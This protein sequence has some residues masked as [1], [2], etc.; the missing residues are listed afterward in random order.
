MLKISRF[1][2]LPSIFREKMQYSPSTRRLKSRY[3]L[4]VPLPRLGEGF[5]VRAKGVQVYAALY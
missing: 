2:N 3:R 1:I 4:K 5:R